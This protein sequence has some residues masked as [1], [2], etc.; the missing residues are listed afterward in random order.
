MRDNPEAL[1]TEK[2]LCGDLIRKEEM[3]CS[4]ACHYS[5]SKNG[6]KSF[7]TNRLFLVYVCCTCAF[8]MHIAS[9]T[10]LVISSLSE[11]C[12]CVRDCENVDIVGYAVRKLLRI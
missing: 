1:F 8:L 5:F 10:K 7:W 11:N 2:Q 4:L 12:F 6:A 9:V 3:L